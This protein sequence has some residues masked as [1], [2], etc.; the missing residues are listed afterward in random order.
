MN[1]SQF[2]KSSDACLQ[3][4][5]RLWED[6]RHMSDFEHLPSAYALSILAQ[7]EFA[8]AFLLHL[9]GEHI[10]PWNTEIQRSLQDHSCKHL[11]VL[12]MDWLNPPTEEFIAT[13]KKPLELEEPYSPSHVA[14]ALN[15]YRHEKIG[16]WE[17]RNWCWVEE[18]EYDSAAKKV[19]QGY[20][21]RLKQ[22]ALYVRISKTGE[23]A[24]LPS[25]ITGNE[26]EKEL[27][28]SER[29][30]ELVKQLNKGEIVFSIE[31]EDLKA[32]IKALFA[33]E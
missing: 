22:D 25:A 26:V 3:N 10:I 6:A 2:F 32:T 8:K 27:E 4:G 19:S 31:F 9:I 1:T 21:D 11:L 13:L 17:S 28:K 12:V 18:P 20:I 24:S 14:S 7:E 16:R 29:L 23:I 5:E 30:G 15:I 33:Y